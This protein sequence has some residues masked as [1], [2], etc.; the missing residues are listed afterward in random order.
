M[1]K[2]LP[3][4]AGYTCSVPGWGPRILHVMRQLSPHALMKTQFSQK[5]K[6]KNKTGRAFWAEGISSTKRP[7]KQEWTWH[8]QGAKNRTMRLGA[9]S[10][11][12]G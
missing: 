4:N 9:W 6:N 10:R 2:N 8:V 3:S 7:K 1:V 5:K 12:K 11:S